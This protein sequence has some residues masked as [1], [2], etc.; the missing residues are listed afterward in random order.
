MQNVLTTLFLCSATMSALALIYIAAT[1]LLA[2][3]YSATGRYYAWLVLV[4][5]LLVPYRPHIRSAMFQVKMPG[6]TAANLPAVPMGAGITAAR[7]T[8]HAVPTVLPLI[9]WWQLAAVVWLTGM[10][11]FLTYHGIRHT[12]FLN[13]TARWSRDVTEEQTLDLFQSLKT[14]MHLTKPIGLKVCDSIGSPMMIGFLHPRILLP[15]ID[16]AADE[17]RFILKHELVHCK[18]KDLWYKGLVLI[19]TAVHWFNPIV[20]VMAKAIDIQCELSCDREVI[21]DTGSDT[22]LSYT[23]TIIG[24]V[25]YQSGRRTALSTYFYGG[26]KGMKDR[27]YS[28]MDTRKKKAGAVVICGAL[29]L[30]LGTGAAFAAKTEPPLPPNTTGSPLADAPWLSINFVPEPG[31][32][33]P[34][35]P[36]GLSISADGSKLLYQGAPVRQFVDE[37]ADGWAFYLDETG[38]ANLSAVRNAAG[39]ITEI[40]KITAQKAQDYYEKFFKEDLNP[41]SVKQI[42]NEQVQEVVNEL[43]QEGQQKYEK[44]RPFGITYSD[45]DKTLAYNGQRVK[46]FIDQPA[47]GSPDVL[48]TDETGTVNVSAIHDASGQ[49][50][51]VETIS[52][53]KAREYQS[54]I[55][56]R[57]ESIEADAENRSRQLEAEIEASV[58]ADINQLF[59]N[60]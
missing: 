45:A 26:K 17:L 37:Q 58:E 3:R 24:V 41:N 12:R 25:R 10:L 53:Q 14:Q 9:S 33:A 18:R 22:R 31:T 13:M 48:W 19:A 39:E 28:I 15:N 6:G 57:N 7:L 27:I 55:D 42:D 1:P 47:A 49:V 36:L 4:I 23:E 8:P 35:V 52:G 29:M 11:L 5:G 30:T 50:T 46:F 59:P 16:F 43:E 32:Y 40:Q 21:R 38:E 51:G 20:Y 60:D 2:K 56:A 54:A 34:Y 44:Y